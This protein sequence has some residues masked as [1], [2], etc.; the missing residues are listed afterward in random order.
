MGQ[1]SLLATPTRRDGARRGP[2]LSL[3]ALLRD[4]SRHRLVSLPL[5]LV[6]SPIE[7][8]KLLAPSG[9]LLLQRDTLGC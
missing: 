5:Q 6:G 8:Q 9:D 2:V 3:A 4:G 7:L 1:S